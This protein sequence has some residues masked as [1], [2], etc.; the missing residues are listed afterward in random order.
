VVVVHKYLKKGGIYVCAVIFEVKMMLDALFASLARFSGCNT[1]LSISLQNSWGKLI[2]I[3]VECKIR[4]LYSS[5][6]F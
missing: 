1:H 5:R 2:S 4:R 3:S 6:L